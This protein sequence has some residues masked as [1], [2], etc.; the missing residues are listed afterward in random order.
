[1]LT[2]EGRAFLAQ[3]EAFW[4]QV[5]TMIQQAFAACFPP[6]RSFRSIGRHGLRNDT[7]ILL[8]YQMPSTDR[9]GLLR[10]ARQA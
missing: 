8:A 1:M 7:M 3:Y 6:Q 4:V 2:P 5:D 10:P 9:L